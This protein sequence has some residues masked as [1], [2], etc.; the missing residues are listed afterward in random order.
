MPPRLL[1]SGVALSSTNPALLCYE[2]S[3][4]LE[5]FTTSS[6]SDG[7]DRVLFL[8]Y[9]LCDFRG[10][11]R[12]STGFDSGSQALASSLRN[13]MTK[14]LQIELHC[15]LLMYYESDM[16]HLIQR[17]DY[18]KLPRGLGMRRHTRPAASPGSS[19]RRPSK[20]QPSS[21]YLLIMP[22]I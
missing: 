11:G 13:E 17:L 16:L 14:T 18:D 10:R 1:A 19:V 3:F 9:H 7:L 15:C 6:L 21:L 12:T 2:R 4:V 22:N 20:L 8:L 5:S